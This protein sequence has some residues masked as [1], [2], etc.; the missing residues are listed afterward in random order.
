MRA[1]VVKAFD[2]PLVV[3]DRPMP[4][5]G[6]GRVRIRLEASGLC[7]TDIHLARGDRPVRPQPPSVPGHEAARLVARPGS[8][9]TAFRAIRTAGVRAGELVAVFGVGEVLADR[10]DRVRPAYLTIPPFETRRDG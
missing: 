2:E 3:A 7:R 1:A 6:P 10:A 8:G 4:R 9:V 5:P